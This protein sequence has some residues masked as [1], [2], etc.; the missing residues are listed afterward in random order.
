MCNFFINSSERCPYENIPN[1]E[2]CI[3]HL[4]SDEK[5]IEKFNSE[6]KLI[7]KSEQDIK[8]QGF[9]FPPGTGN[10]ERESFDKNVCFENAIFKGEINFRSVKF[11]G[12]I[13]DFTG[14]KFEQ[15]VDFT[16]AEFKEA[17]FTKVEFSSDVIFLNTKFTEKVEF[18]N[19]KFFGDVAFPKA[20][21]KDLDFTNSKFFENVGFQDAEFNGKIDYSNVIFKGNMFFINKKSLRVKFDN[22]I[23]SDG[24]RI[25]ANM[26]K[27]SFNGSNIDRV[28]LTSC[29]WPS[30][31]EKDITIWEDRNDKVNLSDLVVIYR[32]LKQ[33]C[34]NNGDQFNAGAFYYQEMDCKRKQM[35]G[36]QRLIWEIFFKR[37]CGY[38]E[39]PYN[40]I[41]I[42][43]LFITLCSI[44]YFMLPVI[45]EQFNSCFFSG[46]VSFDNKIINQG[47]DSMIE[48]L[49]D[50]CNSFYFSVVT[51]TTLS[52][53]DFHPLGLAKALVMIES[54]IGAFMTAVFV[55]VFVRKM[56]R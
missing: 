32:R 8:F 13:T 12:E 25:Q 40:I 19:T 33:S 38:G 39:K 20:V 23:F 11:C 3:F 42:S 44:I 43:L 35:E 26:T 50:F 2:H 47:N 45:S 53:G 7:F 21:F 9:Y 18:N 31:N 29:E 46:V 15:K 5:N 28:D 34:Q 56:M 37:L 10:F 27:C 4:R 55:F 51:F 22:A 14:A 24:A 17:K 30:D 1:T 6:I 16:L 54:F 36:Y 52:Y 49:I 41:K 48:Y